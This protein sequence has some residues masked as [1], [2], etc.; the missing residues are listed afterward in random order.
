MEV[1][2]GQFA[3]KAR[4]SPFMGM[5][6]TQKRWSKATRCLLRMRKPRIAPMAGR[7]TKGESKNAPRI[8]LGVVEGLGMVRIGMLVD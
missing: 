7:M 6:A 1:V 8:I 3:T 5:Q 4:V 2:M